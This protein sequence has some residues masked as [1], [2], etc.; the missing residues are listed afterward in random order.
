MPELALKKET[1]LKKE[2][3]SEELLQLVVFQLG[4]EEFGLD[5]MQV[6]EIIR[7]PEITRIPH[8]PDY[9]KGV[10]NLRGKIITVINLDTR[11]GMEQKVHDDNS[12]IIVAEVDE[13]VVGMV[14]DSVSEVLRL[15]L[16]TV[17]PVPEIISTK[18][19]ANYLKGVGKLE[20]RMLIL[21]DIT[22]VI[23]E[24]APSKVAYC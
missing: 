9:V 10:I 4:E 16:S 7:I 2:T 19:N 1:G 8:S 3:R 21:L 18:I 20:D 22:K 5:I 14:V 11:F 6:Q 12:R 23:M 13:N 17:E 15:P 24:D